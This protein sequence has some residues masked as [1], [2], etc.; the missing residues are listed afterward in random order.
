LK[1]TDFLHAFS[2]TVLSSFFIATGKTLPNSAPVMMDRIAKKIANIPYI[3]KAV[4]DGADLSAF[5]EKLNARIYIGLFIIAWSY[6][7]GWPAVAFFGILSIYFR[8]PLLFVVGGPLIYGFSHV[9]FW[10]GL[11]LA[12]SRYAVALMRWGVRKLFE[13]TVRKYSK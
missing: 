13:K 3:R 1:K 10:F 12:G 2:D 6:I 8:E 7:L 5:R 4:E 11:Y 9:L